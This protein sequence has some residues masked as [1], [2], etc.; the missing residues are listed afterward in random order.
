MVRILEHPC[1]SKRSKIYNIQSNFEPI[2]SRFPSML[3]VAKHAH[4][5]LWPRLAAGKY[6]THLDKISFSNI[7]SPKISYHLSNLEILSFIFQKALRLL[8]SVFKAQFYVQKTWAFELQNCKNEYF[9]YNI[10]RVLYN[11]S[12]LF[13]LSV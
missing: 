6:C 12:G 11:P 5:A 3:H 7:F 4:S 10:S 13:I 9:E 8:K 2:L 1:L